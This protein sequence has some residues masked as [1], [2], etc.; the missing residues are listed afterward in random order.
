MTSAPRP[1]GRHRAR[2]EWVDTDAAGIYHNTTIVR[3][4]EAAEAA[5]MRERGIDGYFPAAPR[6]RYEVDFERPLTFGQEVTTTV[7][8]EH[9]GESSMTFAFEVWGEQFESRPRS[10]AAHGRYVTVHIRGSHSDGTAS[11]TPWPPAWRQ[12]LAA[13]DLTAQVQDDV[14]Q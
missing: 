8:L 6:V 11:S 4:V 14:P 2:I 7:E 10:R 3:F 5:L 9:L 13:A 1:T 12:I